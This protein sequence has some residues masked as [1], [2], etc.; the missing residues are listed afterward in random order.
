MIPHGYEW[1]SKVDP[2]PRMIDIALSEVGTVETPGSGNSPKIMAWAKETGLSADGYT[3]DSVPWCGL[4]A[5]LVASRAGYI[6]PKHPLWALNWLGFGEAAQQPCLGDIL[7]FIRDGGGH[8][9]FYIGEDASA[10]AVL[11]GNTSDAV[12]IGWIAK[13]RMKGA[14]S[15]LYKVGR[16]ASSKPYIIAR[17]GALSRNEA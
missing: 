11:G 5:S 14:R 10:Y 3:A 2:L 13:T 15:P 4:F 9:G 16:P 12:R 17:T 8:V 1:L 6:V 7:V